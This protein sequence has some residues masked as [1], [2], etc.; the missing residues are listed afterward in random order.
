MPVWVKFRELSMA[1]NGRG[2]IE[3]HQEFC[4]KI[5]YGIIDESISG[6]HKALYEAIVWYN[7]INVK[8]K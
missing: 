2:I 8:Q 7:S 5:G 4:S 1:T 6:A 3:K